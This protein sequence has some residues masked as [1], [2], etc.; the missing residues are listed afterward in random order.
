M[1]VFSSPDMARGSACFPLH[2]LVADWFRLKASPSER[3]PYVLDGMGILCQYVEATD[4][5]KTLYASLTEI[6]SQVDAYLRTAEECL[7]LTNM[8]QRSE[9]QKVAGVFAELYWYSGHFTLSLGLHQQI[10]TGHKTAFGLHHI[11][12]LDTV[13]NLGMLYREQGDQAQAEVMLERALAGY[14]KALGLDHVS[15]LSTV[16][17]LGI[18]YRGQGKLDEAERM[19]VQAL[20]EYQ[21]ALGPDHVSTLNTV[22]SLGIF[23]RE[24]GKLVK[25]EPMLVRALVEKEKALGPV[26]VFTLKTIHNLGVLYREQ[27]KLVEAKEIFERALAGYQKALGPDH[28]STLYTVH[29]LGILYV[30]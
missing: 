19:Y 21:K 18:L 25:A 14:E 10:L 3:Q 29:N 6:Q 2:P 13:H 26:D 4:Y 17:N 27:D 11:V 30:N 12:T 22:H 24:Q 20:D 1:V 8:W 7:S 15:T 23:Y 28:V 16:H 9:V 5:V